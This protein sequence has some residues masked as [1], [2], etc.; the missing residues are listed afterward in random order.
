VERFRLGRM[1]VRQ[2]GTELKQAGLPDEEPL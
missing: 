2:F 1:I